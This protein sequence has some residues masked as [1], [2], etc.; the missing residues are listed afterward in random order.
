MNDDRAT[1]PA[2]AQEAGAAALVFEHVVKAFGGVRAVDDLDLAIRVGECTAVIGPN[3]AGKTTLFNLASGFLSADSGKITFRGEDLRR[4]H[5]Q[6]IVRRGITRTFQELRLFGRLSV[7]DNVRLAAGGAETR[8]ILEG[9]NIADIRDSQVDQ[10]SYAEQKLVALARAAASRP[11]LLLLDEP[12]SGLDRPS[13]DR[14]L[15]TLGRL[16]AQG[17]GLCIIEHNLEIVRRLDAR[18]VCLDLGHVFAEGSFDELRARRDVFEIF[19]G[20]EGDE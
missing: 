4:L 3:G 13:A 7:W 10:L 19:F 8:G 1:A 20:S 17:V 11:Q 14:M 15:D 5:P 16:V 18:V 9:L 12:T 2:L 6:H